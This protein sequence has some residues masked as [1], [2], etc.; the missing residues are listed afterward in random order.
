MVI[1]GGLDLKV[2]LIS[3]TNPMMSMKHTVE[4]VYLLLWKFALAK[5]DAET[6][7]EDLT[8][9]HSKLSKVKKIIYIKI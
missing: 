7:H 8:C 2:D 3:P 1:E 5:D 4:V 9:I 6:A